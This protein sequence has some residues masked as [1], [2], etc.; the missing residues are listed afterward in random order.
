[1]TL[2]KRA[3]WLTRLG[4]TA[5]A[6]LSLLVLASWALPRWIES[7]GVERASQM[8]G[9]PVHLESARFEPWRLGLVLNG[10]RID[11]PAGGDAPLL[12]LRRLDAALSL[13]SI[14]HFSPV[15][16]S[17]KIEAP[18]LRLSRLAPGRYDIDDLIQRF[19]ASSEPADQAASSAGVALYNIEL[20]EGQ[21]LL[22]DVPAGSQHVLSELRL[23]LPFISTLEADVEVHV[24]PL[25]SG[26]L[27]GA[28]FQNKADAQPFAKTRSAQLSLHLDELDLKPYRGYWPK[29]SPVNVSQ[30]LLAADLAVNFAKPEGK[31]PSVSIS[32]SIKTRD[33]AV[34]QGD[35]P[36]LSWQALSLQLADVQPLLRSAKLA[37]LSWQ[38]PVLQ[39]RRRAD[40]RLAL[41]GLAD[42]SPP[43]AVASSATST[44]PAWRLQLDRFSLAGG[45]LGWRDES[46]KPAA[47]L[48]L[49]DLNLKL[50]QLQWPLAGEAGLELQALLSPPNATDSA[51]VSAQGRLRPV[52]MD[53][54]AALQGL[55]LAWF[56]PYTAALSPLKLQGL[57][58]AEAHLA[59]PM[60]EGA[61]GAPS[62]TLKNL[63]LQA[64]KAWERGDARAAPSLQW[65]SVQLDQA[66]LDLGKR[67]ASLGQLSIVEPRLA[68]RRAADGRWNLQ[69]WQSAGAAAPSAGSAAAAPAW[70]LKLR[71]LQL[72][73][74]RV[75]LQ[76]ALAHPVGEHAAAEQ[77]ILVDELKLELADLAW[78]ANARSPRLPASLSLALTQLGA[79]AAKPAERGRLSWRG[80]L[81]LQPFGLQGALRAERLPLQLL[82]AYLDPQLG[83]H[84][85]H[86]ELGLKAQL[87]LA[88]AAEGLQ[89]RLD[90]DLLLA[91]LRLQQARLRDGQRVLGED[92]LNW[93]ALNLAGLKLALQPGQAPRVHVEQA[94]L[95]DFYARLIISEEGQFN[96][97]DLGAAERQQ[98]AEVAAAASA[99]ASAASAPPAMGKPLISV[100]QTRV[101]N[102]RVDFSDRYIR[103][104]Y[105]AKLSDLNGGLGAFSSER[106]EM[107][108]LN[109]KGRVA[110]TG[111]LDINGRI[112][113]GVSP[114]VMDLKASATDIE[115]A[116]LSPY[117]GKYA[118]YAIERG[119]LST[120]LQYRIEPGGALQ[121]ENQV[122]LNQ[123]TFGE[124]IES[125]DAT[126]LPVLLAVAL[127]KDRLGVIDVNLPI[128]GSIND[129]QFSVG[130]LVFKLILN[131]LGKAL[132][133][134]FSLLAGGGGPDLSQVEFVPGAPLLAENSASALDK[135]AK[136]LLDRPQLNLTVTAYA[137]P[138]TEMQVMQQL[139]VEQLLVQERRRELQR[140][141][142][143]QAQA[144]AESS[145]SLSEAERQRLL[146]QVYGGAKLP[147]KPRNVIGLAKDIPA[148]EMRALLAA[149]HKVTP[150][151][152]RQ[153]ALERG[154]AVRDAL[155]A[156]GVPNE[157][158]FVASPKLAAADEGA[159]SKPWLPHADLTLAAQ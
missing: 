15:L 71:A 134:P 65:A 24:Q 130:G 153:L 7:S 151:M 141:Q 131:L 77:G 126:K 32:G 45:Q 41:P 17:L 100:A 50:T 1:M 150:E 149:D 120:R 84:L 152:L 79:P 115:L 42:A 158:L 118:G 144:D 53:I 72:A 122:I 69:S 56:A 14:W 68:L 10:L 142:T 61:A 58:Q 52:G 36:L 60:G 49:R 140:Q 95:N 99:A 3:P 54:D 63:N 8:L 74:G 18:V 40:G 87:S 38:A 16:A 124:R 101:L 139:H 31:A 21:V 155:I 97:R 121:A 25:L 67:S 82:D 112:N 135:L 113:P 75:S 43:A 2:T 6:L 108:E 64:L 28:R 92:L 138:A 30:G 70:A 78:P 116:P 51:R 105:S 26:R 132:T 29:S 5:L 123:L 46:S 37:D 90:G 156:R 96:L 103:P 107:A 35:Q 85:A 119:K 83:L 88:S 34:Q 9:R 48:G 76:D 128:S 136:A 93:Q 143:A 86:A 73:K 98:V 146:K 159:E 129:P 109:L 59:W 91:D 111:L 114:P 133:A 154:V 44:N 55:Q 81:G 33:L 94:S 147:N 22:N 104:N 13:R 102:G 145:I 66:E 157:R 106:S 127:L 11:G 39:L 117:A 4:A 12:S 89:A 20:S 137:N 125:P 57:A 62:I 27:N 148:A 80:K 110:G 23:D 47:E 19:G